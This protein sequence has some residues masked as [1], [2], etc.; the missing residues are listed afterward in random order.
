MNNWTEFIISNII[1]EQSKSKLQVQNAINHGIY[2]F[3]TSG[4]KILKHTDYLIDGDNIFLATGGVANVK[5]YSGKCAYS[6]DT[7]AI[8]CKDFDAKYFYYFLLE[9]KDF[10][11][12][13]LFSGSGLKHLQKKDFY[14]ICFK[15]PIDNNER[16]KIAQILSTIDGVIEKTQGA[17]V[18]YK[19]IKQGMVNDLFTRGIDLKTGKLRPKQEHAPELYKESKLGWIPQEWSLE[20]LEDLVEIDTE[21]L[22]TSTDSNF[23]FYYIDISSVST[24]TILYP[25]NRIKFKNSPSRARKV[26]RYNNILLAT[27]RPNLKAFAHFK[28]ETTFP[29]IASTGFSVLH[30]KTNTN[31][32]FVYQILFSEYIEKQIE[33]V[34][35]GSNYPAINS[36]DVRD[37]KVMTPDYTEQKA[38]SKTLLS[39]D[40]KIESEQ[41]YLKKLQQIIS[42]LMADLLSGNKLVPFPKALKN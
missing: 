34:V 18:K 15:A 35:V 1:V 32:D 4:E 6:T 22:S 10:I 2:P 36:S 16:K 11:N 41:I 19:A 12:N 33:A 8:K 38:I 20:R 28:R 39:I 23:S 21:Q 37:L 13:N 24:G 25:S 3:F 9:K 27:V 29:H 31:I 30:E 26:V 5:Y 42:G 17:I 14:K 40:Q 7:Y